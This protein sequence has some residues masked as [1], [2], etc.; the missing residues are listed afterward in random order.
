MANTHVQKGDIITWTNGTGANVASGAV[1]IIGSLVAVALVDIANGAAGSV[2]ISE[3]WS[4]EKNTSLAIAAGDAL[5]WDVADG[6]INKTSADNYYAGVAVAAAGA[7]DTTVAVKLGAERLPTAVTMAPGS[8]FAGTGTIYKSS[9]VKE[10][11][12]YKTSIFIDLTG[13]SSS[14]TDL[15]IIGT[16]ATNPANIGQITAAVNG[17]IIGGKVTCLELPAGGADDI[18]LYSATVGTGAFD[19][20]IAA[21]T[22]TALIT[23]GGA[24]ASGTTKGMTAVPAANSYL[25]LTGGEAGTAAAYTAG[26]FLIEFWGM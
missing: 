12:L 8:G 2:A 5:Y 25:Y 21:L 1:V 20:G 22:G 6:E 11:E 10:G 4:L 17:T 19:G 7:T 23:A 3:V 9:V 26:K 15:D 13:A 14:T 24:W 16:H 18:D